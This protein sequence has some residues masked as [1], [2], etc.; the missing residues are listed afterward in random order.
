MK[1]LTGLIAAT[2]TPMNPDG[3]LKLDIIPAIVDRLVANDI[4]GLYVC[5][6]T[7]E[8]PLLTTEERRA[9]AQAYVTAAAGRIPVVVQVGHTSNHEARGLAAHAA[10]IGAD[11]LSALPPTYFKPDG[12]DMLIACLREVVSGAPDL[13]F[14]Y[15]HIPKLTDVALDMTEMLRR[16]PEELPSL[17]G[18][19]FSSY[20]QH[21]FQACVEQAGDKHTMLFG[22]DESCISGH[23]LGAAGAV[24][25]TYNFMAPLYHTAKA[26]YDAGNTKEAFALQADAGRI[27]R[28]MLAYKGMAGLKAAMKITGLDCGPCRLPLYSLSDEECAAFE[29]ELSAVGFDQ[30]AMK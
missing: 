10:S 18:I 11:A 16:G 14:Y 23:A 29:K 13:P 15:Y 12:M 6:S 2:V 21:E 8:G 27:I 22:V 24:G 3:S 25:S 28:V 4:G 9:V 17:A 5:G 26:A 30:W 20:T 1:T 19:K 7:G